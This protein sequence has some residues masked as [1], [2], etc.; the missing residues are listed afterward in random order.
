M[1]AADIEADP[2]DA[3][4]CSVGRRAWRSFALGSLVTFALMA[5]W[6]L[7]MPIYSGPDEPS[8]AAHAAALVRGQL[9]GIPT[10]PPGAIATVTVPGTLGE[11]QQ[12][13]KCF[14]YAPQTSASCAASVR[15]TSRPVA[16]L[17]YSARYP[18]LYFA[19]T[20]LI[21]LVD[22]SSNAL[23]LMRLVSALLSAVMLGLAYMTLAVWSTNRLLPVG[24]LAALTPTA[25]YLGGMVNPNGLEVAAAI[26]LWCAGMVLA[27]EHSQQPPPSL[28]VVAAVSG[29][30]LICSRAL[31]PLFAVLI[32][33]TLV[34]LSGSKKVG[35]LLSTR[36]DVRWATLVLGILTVASALWIVLVHSLWVLSSGA[37][38]SPTATGLSIVGKAF[39]QTRIWLEQ[40]V[41]VF[42]WND[43]YAP[44]WTYRIWAV[45]ILVLVLLAVRSG[46][47][48]G[49]VLVGWLVMLSF[50]L[51]VV[52]SLP[53]A[54]S[55]GIGWQGRYT[56]PLAVGIPILCAALGGQDMLKVQGVRSICIGRALI[57]CLSL[58]SLLAYLEALRRYSVGIYGPL[59]FLGGPWKPVEGWPLALGGYVVV[60]G[61]LASLLWRLTYPCALAGRDREL[62]LAESAAVPAV[63]S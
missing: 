20:G 48:R 1:V 34:A 55:I 14:Q 51:P 52:L 33:L 50:V 39:S 42:G 63:R 10:N 38:V 16:A 15:L 60:S 41:G 49:L 11:G 57:L 45:V 18:P 30:V 19:L 3:S 8:H 13:I 54:H 24:F 58:A 32:L 31:S 56:L 28:V 5:M 36:R 22:H 12:D 7:T 29:G 59:D 46:Y 35:H 21:S 2:Q 37:R 4:R 25:V 61:L 27:L 23:I 6:A 53:S 44:T 47:R 43:T 62:T 40:M 17:S 26:S 9:I